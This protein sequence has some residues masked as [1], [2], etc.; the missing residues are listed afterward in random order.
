MSVIVSMDIVVYGTDDAE[1]V[2]VAFA[3]DTYELRTR[4]ELEVSK[5]VKRMGA[6]AG[7]SALVNMRTRVR[8][9]RE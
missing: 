7:A 1:A 3:A 2:R 5:A 8:K 4:I 9:D 6:S